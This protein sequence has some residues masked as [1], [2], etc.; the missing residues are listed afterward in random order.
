MLPQL[1]T[2]F[3]FCVITKF[4]KSKPNM[5]LLSFKPKPFV[6][7]LLVALIRKLQ[8]H[9]NITISDSPSDTCTILAPHKN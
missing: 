4:R 3:H 2:N 5:L 6:A 9:Q 8:I 7:F 1:H